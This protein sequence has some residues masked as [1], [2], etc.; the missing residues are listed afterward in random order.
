MDG[1]QR[2]FFPLSFRASARFFPRLRSVL[3]GASFSPRPTHGV[4]DA[5]A[6]FSPRFCVPVLRQGLSCSGALFFTGPSRVR[7]FFG[8]KGACSCFATSLP[9]GPMPPGRISSG[10][11]ERGAE[12]AGKGGRPPAFFR[13]GSVGRSC[14]QACGRN[15]LRNCFKVGRAGS[16]PPDRS[17]AFLCGASGMKRA[18]RRASTRLCR[19]RFPAVRNIPADGSVLSSGDEAGR[20]F[21]F[22][23]AFSCDGQGR[24]SV[25]SE[26]R[27][28]RG[29]AVFMKAATDRH[30]AGGGVSEEG[31]LHDRRTAVASLRR[32]RLE[33]KRRVKAGK[34]RFP[35]GEMCQ[36]CD[37]RFSA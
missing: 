31:H 30:H 11:D 5:P 37:N 2:A 25:F 7:R 17:A 26:C 8:A 12:T 14:P 16:C 27:S 18:L 33:G 22:C 3:T 13:S 19:K 10:L 36:N 28:R 34:A 1:A 9:T 20:S 32:R 24:K 21:F 4:S 35:S 23:P 29:S 6:L 15:G